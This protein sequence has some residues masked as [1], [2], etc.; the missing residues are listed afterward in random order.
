MDVDDRIKKQLEKINSGKMNAYIKALDGSDFGLYI[1]SYVDGEMVKPLAEGFSQSE[2]NLKVTIKNISDA[3]TDDSLVV[4]WMGNISNKPSQ[5]RGGHNSCTGH[6]ESHSE[7]TKNCKGHPNKGAW[8]KHDQ[9]TNAPPL[10]YKS[11]LELLKEK[12]DI[13]DSIAKD[14]FGLALLHG[15]NNES[16]FTK[17][18]AEYVSVISNGKTSFRK[19]MDVLN[20]VTFV[21][22]TWRSIDGI[23]RVAGGFSKK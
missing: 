23:I 11:S 9:L 1:P 3:R 22:N 7:P 17:L 21:P 6:C 2:N 12:Q 4:G 19:E 13:L 5:C 14:D 8:H 10:D 15:H 16:P 20:D 18:P